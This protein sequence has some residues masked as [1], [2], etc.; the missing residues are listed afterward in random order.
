M[1]VRGEL[2]GVRGE[3]T[4]RFAFLFMGVRGG[5]RRELKGVNGEICFSFY[6]S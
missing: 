4:V 6:G 5:V 1:G 3:L 2:K